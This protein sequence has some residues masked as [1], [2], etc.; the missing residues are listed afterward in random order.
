MEV[1][2]LIAA[3]I[4]TTEAVSTAVKC[5][6][7][8]RDA[9]EDRARFAKEAGF[10]LELLVRFKS[11]AETTDPSDAWFQRFCFLGTPTGPLTQLKNS[12]EMVTAKLLIALQNGDARKLERSLLWPREKKKLNDLFV[13]MERLKTT[14]GM[15]LQ[16]E[17][18]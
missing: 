16:M 1:F 7:E 11:K 6:S 5:I 13:Q 15:A 17:A 12:M 2:G 14:I 3:V 9:P 4:Q 18:M 8:M 10:L